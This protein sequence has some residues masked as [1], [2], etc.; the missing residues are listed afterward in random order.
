MIEGSGADPGKRWHVDDHI[1]QL[2]RAIVVAVVVAFR[3][4]LATGPWL[5]R[6]RIMPGW[7]PACGSE[8]RRG[9]PARPCI[10]RLCR[11][12]ERSGRDQ[13]AT[14]LKLNTEM[15]NGPE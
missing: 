8:T 4:L 14:L 12:H 9:W 2:R 15:P 6:C 1:R 3:R 7:I 5:T 13:A 10:P 11:I